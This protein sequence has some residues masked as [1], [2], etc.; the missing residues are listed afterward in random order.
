[1][2]KQC[3][4]CQIAV[5]QSIDGELSD[6]LKK[7]MFLHLATCKDCQTF[8]ES[9]LD[10]K[11]GA[12][13]QQRMNTSSSLDWRVGSLAQIRRAGQ[14]KNDRP[15]SSSRFAPDK[16]PLPQHSEERMISIPIPSLML[17][18]STFCIG[19]LFIV[20]VLFSGSRT[21]EERAF[22]DQPVLSL[23]ARSPN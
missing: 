19:L 23:P 2:K 10:L 13:Q 9:V 5:S 12:K 22:G 20:A 15:I 14:A 4:N 6:R 7:D 8:W 18:L 17:F 3:I 11:L 16:G 1:M 21:S